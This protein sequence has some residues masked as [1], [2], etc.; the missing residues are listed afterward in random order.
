MSPYVSQRHSDNVMTYSECASGSCSA[1]L[2][3]RK[4]AIQRHRY[5]KTTVVECPKFQYALGL[6]E[7]D[8]KILEYVGE[9]IGKAEF[10]RRKLMAWMDTLPPSHENK[11]YNSESYA[12]L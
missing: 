2:N 8:T 4:N 5:P 7:A 6:E 9:R 1:G 10:T 12:F 3:C 11:G